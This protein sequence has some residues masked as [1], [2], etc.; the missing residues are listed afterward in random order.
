MEANKIEI[1]ILLRGAP[2]G[3]PSESE[4]RIQFG[5]AKRGFACMCVNGAPSVAVDTG[6]PENSDVAGTREPL[7]GIGH[8]NGGV[9]H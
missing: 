1:I 5:N 3:M 2:I 7:V 8:V 9:E 4:Q 6:S